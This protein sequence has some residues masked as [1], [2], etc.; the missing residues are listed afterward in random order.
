MNDPKQYVP[1]QNNRSTGLFESLFALLQKSVYII[2]VLVTLTFT[3]ILFYMLPTYF[4]RLVTSLVVCTPV[5]FW[6][7]FNN[8]PADHVAIVVDSRSRRVSRILR[9]GKSFIMPFTESLLYIRG[10]CLLNVNLVTIEL[11][12]K[13]RDQEF[14]VAIDIRV[15]NI[16]H[17]FNKE[18]AEKNPE[19]F[20]YIYDSQ[21]L[22]QFVKTQMKM[23][24]RNFLDQCCETINKKKL[25]VSKIKLVDQLKKTIDSGLSK[26]QTLAIKNDVVGAGTSSTKPVMDYFKIEDFTIFENGSSNIGCP[27]HAFDMLLPPTPRQII[28]ATVHM[29]GLYTNPKTSE[30]D[31][32]R[33]FSSV[34]S[35]INSM[36]SNGIDIEK[37]PLLKKCDLPL[38]PVE[39]VKP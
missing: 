27:K 33:L 30:E 25:D 28:S 20:P 6:W 22:Q 14:S 3:L 2:G 9:P 32:C 21:G 12:C 37:I 38:G 19:E 29:M 26:N 17:L 1:I 16:R 31:R 18:L 11:D 10:N 5:M 4:D 24:C 15:K 7:N 36:I 34:V 23:F 8:I 13:V 39:T 35:Q